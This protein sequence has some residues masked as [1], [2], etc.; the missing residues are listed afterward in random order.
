MAFTTTTDNF[1]FWLQTESRF[2]EGVVRQLP[3]T[4][5]DWGVSRVCAVIDGGLRNN[6]H[7]AELKD[8]LKTTFAE[9][10]VAESDVAEPDYD[11]LDEFKAQFSPDYD[12]MIA[13]GG[14]STLDVPEVAPV[15]D[16]NS[17]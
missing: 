8:R 2:G 17:I 5:K 10:F 1:S 14:G 16:R 15:V 9:L 7:V 11:Y 6:Q 13:I 12:V 3:D 4:L